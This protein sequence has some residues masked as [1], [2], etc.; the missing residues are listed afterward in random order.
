M[1]SASK[2]RTI[3]EFD[4]FQLVPGEELL[5]RKGEP[6]GLNIKSLSVLRM[7]VEHHGHLVTKSEIIDTVWNDSF[8]EESSLT[9][10]IWTI[11]QALGDT[12]KERFIQTVP[13]RGYRFIFPVA[14]MTDRSGAFRLSDLSTAGELEADFISEN[15]SAKANGDQNDVWT[16]KPTTPAEHTNGTTGKIAVS[17][18]IHNSALPRSA[19]KVRRST[20]I[21]L[22]V[23]VA[24][25]VATVAILCWYGFVRI[26]AAKTPRSVAILP[27]APINAGERNVGYER[28]IADALIN[29]LSTAEGLNVRPLSAVAGYVDAPTEPLAAGRELKVDYVLASNY[30]LADGKIKVTSRLYN[31]ATGQIED[32]FPTRQTIGDIFAAEDAIAADIGGRVMER[33]GTSAR[34]PSKSRGTDN[35]AAYLAYLQG[36]YLLDRQNPGGENND[37]SPI[38]FFDRAVNLDPHYARAWAAKAMAHNYA[39]LPEPNRDSEHHQKAREAVDRARSIDPNESLVYS[40]LCHQRLFDDWNYAAAEQAG[41]RAVELDPASAFARSE[42]ATVL[43]SRGRNDE[44]IDHL[45]KAMEMAPASFRVQASYANTLFMARRYQEAE[46]QYKAM[47]DLKPDRSATYSWLIRVMEAQN[48][49]TEAVDWTVK[50]MIALNKGD[51]AIQ[52]YK[53]AYESSGYRGAL[54]ERVNSGIMPV[55]AYV[56]LGDRDK[57][58]AAL[59]ENYRRRNYNLAVY[60]I[61]DPVYDPLRGDPR[62][63]DLISRIQK[64]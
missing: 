30:Q 10:A 62:W 2:N 61:V 22:A 5:L 60:G 64:N 33:L 13:R 11:R 35:E 20:Y 58:F 28:G 36:M 9:K 51:E 32:A 44:A 7:L 54:L 17:E 59:E 52:R 38:E 63:A 46:T 1:E 12:S 3:Y 14:V 56:Y 18:E 41:R 27:S 4:G 31:V 21:L 6:V 45:K 26:G 24:G 25:A 34:A 47:V 53:D 16:A 19:T 8:V 43:T 23:C 15:G 37:P 55:H 50:L 49:E 29:R 39:A 42:Y 40:A 48:K 57:A